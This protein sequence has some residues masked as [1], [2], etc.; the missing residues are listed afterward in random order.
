MRPSAHEDVIYD[1]RPSLTGTFRGQPITTNSH[2]MRSREVTL[3]KP[4]GTFRIVGLGDSY[5]FGWGVGQEETYLHLV[6]QR[7]NEPD[8]P[9]GEFEILNFATPGYNGVMQMAAYEHSARFFD[10]DLV[11]VHFIGNDFAWPHFLQAARTSAPRSWYLVDLGR[12]VLGLDDDSAPEL[13]PHDV[14]EP[15]ENEEE[16]ARDRYRYMLGRDGYSQAMDRLAEL[17]KGE[18]IPVIVMMLGVAGPQRQFVIE[19]AESHGFRVLNAMPHFSAIFQAGGFEDSRR[20][21]RGVFNIR[22]D[23]HPT[24]LAHQAYAEAVMSELEDMGIVEAP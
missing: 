4:A 13:L 15:P 19:K 1:L 9:G 12:G 18:S 14:G 24:V 16:E 10:P 5:M 2:G 20:A 11:V 21:W 7:L 8:S 6:E 23:G 17:T 3:R 22:G